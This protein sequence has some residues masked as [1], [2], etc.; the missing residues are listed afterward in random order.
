MNAEKILNHDLMILVS[1]RLSIRLFPTTL[2]RPRFSLTRI[3]RMRQMLQNFHCIAPRGFCFDMLFRRLLVLD[4][5]PDP[6][7]G[8]LFIGKNRDFFAQTSTV[9]FRFHVSLWFR[10]QVPFFTAAIFAITPSTCCQTDPPPSLSVPPHGVC[11][12]PPHDVPVPEHV[13]RHHGPRL[14]G[15]ARPPPPRAVQAAAPRQLPAPPRILPRTALRVDADVHAW[16]R[17]E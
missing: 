3:H 16:V 4:V 17:F 1:C 14:R 7:I 11:P 15:R 9:V 8:Y 10:F 13:H 5:L 2:M 12:H 6:I